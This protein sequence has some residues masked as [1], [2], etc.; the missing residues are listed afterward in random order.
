MPPFFAGAMLAMSA[1][2][3]VW[4]IGQR[5]VVAQLKAGLPVDPVY[6]WRAKQ[7]SVH[8]THFTLPV[9]I[10]MLS[11]H[12]GWLYSGQGQLAGAGRH[13]AGRCVDSPSSWPATRTGVQNWQARLGNVTGLAWP[14]WSAVVVWM[15]PL[16]PSAAAIGCGHRSIY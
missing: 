4:I 6:G 11:N 7:R 2:V 9:L 15:A 10:A 14:R 3:F 5:K 8:N 1:N 12:Y 16:P 13:D